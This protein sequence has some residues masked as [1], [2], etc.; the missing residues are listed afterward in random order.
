[1]NAGS[2]GPFAMA[3]GALLL[4]AGAFVVVLFVQSLFLLWGARIAGIEGRGVGRAM[5]VTILGGLAS[6][7]VSAVLAASGPV[8]PIVGFA[9]GFIVTALVAMPVFRT[10]FGRA[11]GASVLAW[12]LGLLVIGAIALLFVGLG[13]SLAVTG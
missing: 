5:A 7:A 9:A 8:A 4:L 6:I 12:L 10:S 2:V 11:L 13:L 3:G 1:M